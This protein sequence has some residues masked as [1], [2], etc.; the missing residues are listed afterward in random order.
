LGDRVD[1]LVEVAHGARPFGGD[2][3]HEQRARQRLHVGRQ[4]GDHLVGVADQRARD[5]AR[6]L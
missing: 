2:Q 6:S 1:Q 3:L 5:A 4:L